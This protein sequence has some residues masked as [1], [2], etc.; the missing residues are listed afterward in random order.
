MLAVERILMLWSLSRWHSSD[1]LV[2]VQLAALNVV[3]HPASVHSKKSETGNLTM[4]VSTLLSMA[5]I[6]CLSAMAA[7]AR[8]C[9]CEQNSSNSD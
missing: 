8:R 7:E 1:L 4:R 3:L 9:T 6:C 5:G 2:A